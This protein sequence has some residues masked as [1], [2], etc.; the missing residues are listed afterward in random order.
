MLS[1]HKIHLSTSVSMLSYSHRR[2][3][4]L[5][6]WNGISQPCN[7]RITSSS[8]SHASYRLYKAECENPLVREVGFEPTT[9]GVSAL[10]VYLLHRYPRIVC[11]LLIFKVLRR[12]KN[13][14][15]SEL[16]TFKVCRIRLANQQ[17]WICTTHD[18][19]VPIIFDAYLYRFE[20]SRSVFFM[21][22]LQVNLLL[23]LQQSY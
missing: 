16:P 11:F 13:I 12:E 2:Y 18:N 20:S 23:S 1:S 8:T 4:Y 15:N 17:V 22:F 21:P 3:N 9:G 6:D 19:L 7:H 5:K 14:Q 10:C